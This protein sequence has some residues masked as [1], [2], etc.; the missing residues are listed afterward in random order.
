MNNQ[1]RTSFKRWALPK[2]SVQ[3]LVLLAV[4]IA[5]SFILGR[6]SITTQIMRISFVFL[7]SSLMGKWFGPLWT[8]MVMVL[9]DF[10]KTN[11]FGGGHWSPI[12][13]IGVLVA[14]LIYGAFFYQE[15]PD[16]KVAWWKV[17]VAVLFITIL[18]NLLI[19]TAALLVLYSPHKS[20]SVF[21]S[22][23]ATRLPK[24][25][26]FFPIQ[27]LMTYFALNNTVVRDLSKKFFK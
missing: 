1:T 22:M 7:A 17:I 27:V 8:T 11:F 26:I 16:A 10:V 18:V 24:N 2:L 20:W 15:K 25:I 3:Q 6:L 14:G 4:L 9:L 19:N 13:A 12:M 23:M 5:L 21:F